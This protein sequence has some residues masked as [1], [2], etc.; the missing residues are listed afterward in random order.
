MQMVTVQKLW[1]KAEADKVLTNA[2]P[3]WSSDVPH[4][5]ARMEGAAT[6]L[7]N[8]RPPPQF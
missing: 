8:E 1:S 5:E 6:P 7:G 2:Q 4:W 3:G